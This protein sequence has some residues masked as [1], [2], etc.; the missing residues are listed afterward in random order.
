MQ[1]VIGTGRVGGV[2]GNGKADMIAAVPVQIA[3][4]ND[5]AARLGLAAGPVA[6][7]QGREASAGG[8]IPAEVPPF[9]GATGAEADGGDGDAGDGDDGELVDHFRL[10]QSEALAES[11]RRKCS[12]AYLISSLAMISVSHSNSAP[13]PTAPVIRP[14]PIRA[15][16]RGLP[17]A[18]SQPNGSRLNRR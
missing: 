17:I 13:P 1:L 6:I 12:R 14:I 10:L 15:W 18:V 11:N 9:Q 7:K 2:T 8:K 5:V 4:G 16:A 3:A